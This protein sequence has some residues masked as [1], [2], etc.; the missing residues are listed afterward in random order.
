MG[1]YVER[2]ISAL[3]GDSDDAATR[4]LSALQQREDM[5]HWADWLSRA[6]YE[7]RIAR[8]KA[9]FE[10]ASVKQVCGTLANL[11]PANAGDLWALTV[12]HLKQLASEIRDGS[13]NDYGQYW[14]GE[15]PRCE[16]D[17][18][19]AVLSDLKKLL[20]PIGVAAEPEGR[21]AD[22]KRADIKVIAAPHHV[23]IEIKCE[24][25]PHLWK[26]VREQLIA[27][28]G[29]ETS[30]DG[31][32]IY[33]VFWFGAKRMPVAGDGGAKPKTPEELRQRLADTVP[34]ELQ[35]KIAVLVVNC[36]KPAA[37]PPPKKRKQKVS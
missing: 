22:E 24:W 36:E 4:A 2:L 15:S 17:C 26:A 3:A 1:R 11:K 35:G 30:S 14:A 33:L 9:L 34:Q 13:T 8:R 5:K 27:K 12:D 19:D 21:Y 32:G 16:D 7:Q 6:L 23:P 10:P 37:P 18:R 25:H 28:Y 20:N 29:R 31:Y